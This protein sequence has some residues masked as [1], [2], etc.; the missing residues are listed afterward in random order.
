[1]DILHVALPA[2]KLEHANISLIYWYQYNTQWDTEFA[3]DSVPFQKC[4]HHQV[5]LIL[6]LKVMFTSTVSGKN[7]S[8]VDFKDYTVSVEGFFFF[9]FLMKFC[10]GAFFS[11]SKTLVHVC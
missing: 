4:S 2:I 5:C 11:E 7:Y 6:N 9:F 10:Y 3:V 8:T 1:M